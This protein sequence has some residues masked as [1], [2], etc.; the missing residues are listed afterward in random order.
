MSKSRIAIFSGY[1]PPRSYG[2]PIFSNPRLGRRGY[3]VPAERGYGP[4]REGSRTRPLVRKAYKVRKM[5]DTP[6]MKRAQKR[7]KAA[8]KKCSRT[9]RKGGFQKCMKAA[10]KK[11]RK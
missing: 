2:A 5:K 1:A 9:A 3:S 4:L 10:L 8:A 6:A 11:G 7:F